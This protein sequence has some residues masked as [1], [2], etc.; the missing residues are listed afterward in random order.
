MRKG[1]KRTLIVSCLLALSS[2][3]VYGSSLFLYGSSIFDRASEQADSLAYSLASS[4]AESGL[5]ALPNVSN[6]EYAI[7]NADG[8]PLLEYG[9]GLPSSYGLYALAGSALDEGEIGHSSRGGLSSYRAISMVKAE[10]EQGAIIVYAE[11]EAGLFGPSFTRFAL[12]LLFIVLSFSGIE[13][14][15]SGYFLS[16]LGSV[17][18]ASA[19]RIDELACQK[20]LTPLPKCKDPELSSFCEQLDESS[21]ALLRQRRN[22][23]D[24]ESGVRRILDSVSDLIVL[25]EE[26]GKATFLNLSAAKAFH[27]DQGKPHDISSFGFPDEI[28][29]KIKA[30][31]TLETVYPLE[32]S[33]YALR[34]YVTPAGYVIAMADIGFEV[35]MEKVRQSFFASASH[36]LKTPLT[37]ILGQAEILSLLPHEKELDKA[38]DSISSSGKRMLRLIEDMLSLSRIESGHR[39]VS[40]PISLAKAA[41]EARDSLSLLMKE[42]GVE[43]SV[44]GDL[45]YPINYDDAYALIRNL[46]ENGIR[47]GKKDGHVEISFFESGFQVKDDGIG[48][49]KED[50][51]RVFERFYRVEK[52]RSSNL[53]GTGLGLA[54]VKH[55]MLS[56]G[57]EVSVSSSLGEGSVFTCTFKK[58][59]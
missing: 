32:Q 43:V 6:G 40:G 57:G 36:E 8:E 44:K 49:P 12:I 33:H 3:F 11:T 48:I 51:D 2:V 37:A 52:S 26:D 54:I 24:S 7:L 1:R 25:L 14:A 23:E 19:R 47:Y 56:Y 46:L 15:V 39:E 34:G 42:K 4:Y 38:I 20:P 53:G 9:D 5:S 13:I 55:T 50:R 16:S 30:G 31:E 21:F 27:L 29:K 28:E 58:P 59:K 17:M 22:L 45:L 41:F 35:N 10:G 18:S